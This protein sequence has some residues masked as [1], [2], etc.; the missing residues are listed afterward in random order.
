MAQLMAHPEGTASTALCIAFT[1]GIIG[2][3][4]AA[5]GV[6]C[7]V[8]IAVKRY[9]EFIHLKTWRGLVNVNLRCDYF[10]LA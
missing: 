6:F 7:S 10:N 2:C 4:G 9:Y 5:T 1:G 3:V 8:A